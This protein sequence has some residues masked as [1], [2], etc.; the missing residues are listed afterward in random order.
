MSG[1]KQQSVCPFQVP[2]AT[3]L[4][5]TLTHCDRPKVDTY[6]LLSLLQITNPGIFIILS[7]FLLIYL[8]LCISLVWRIVFN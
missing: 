1:S 7:S 3:L 8:M 2:V 5:L 4:R 6:L